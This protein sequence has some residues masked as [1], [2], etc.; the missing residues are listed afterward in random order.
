MNEFHLANL[1]LP[2]RQAADQLLLPHLPE[3]W[4]FSRRNRNRDLTVLIHQRTQREIWYVVLTSSSL[5]KKL[6]EM[7]A[8]PLQKRDGKFSTAVMFTCESIFDIQLTG[9]CVKF[10][11][12]IPASQFP[13]SRFC[14]LKINLVVP[15]V[16]LKCSSSVCSTCCIV[17]FYGFQIE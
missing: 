14:F 10:H 8:K 2:A 13:A 17:V 15:A 6:Q 3:V 7:T 11:P 9:A 5:E 1:F 12:S 16:V 4:F